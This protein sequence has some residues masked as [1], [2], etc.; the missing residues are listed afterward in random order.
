ME[1]RD[2]KFCLETSR[3]TFFCQ[4]LSCLSSRSLI[5]VSFGLVLSLRPVCLVLCVE[6]CIMYCR[7]RD[8][9]EP[10]TYFFLYPIV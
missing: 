7:F 10:M 5:Y 4:I 1:L 9:Y 2:I 6:P 8:T 3:D